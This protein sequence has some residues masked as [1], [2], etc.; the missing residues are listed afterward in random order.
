MIDLLNSQTSEF[1][2][3]SGASASGKATSH[4]GPEALV[5]YSF[6]RFLQAT[7]ITLE[8]YVDAV[9]PALEETGFAEEGVR[10]LPATWRD[11]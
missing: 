6:A 1:A 4:K 3:A 5:F 2:G 10:S 9:K 11:L 7:N 8:T